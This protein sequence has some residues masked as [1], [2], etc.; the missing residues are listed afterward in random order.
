MPRVLLPFRYTLTSPLYAGM[1]RKE[2]VVAG[3]RAINSNT[4]FRLGGINSIHAFTP[5]FAR[6]ALL[7]P[8]ETF[9]V[10]QQLAPWPAIRRAQVK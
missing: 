9:G 4:H 2:G 3:M 8:G 5:I 1:N 7:W 6:N 10:Q